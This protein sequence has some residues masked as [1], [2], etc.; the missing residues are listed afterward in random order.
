MERR[1]RARV[2]QLPEKLVENEGR[3]VV[4]ALFPEGLQAFPVVDE[5]GKKRLHIKRRAVFGPAAFDEAGV[6]E[7]A[8]PEGFEPSL[9]P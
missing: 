3:A 1:L 6:T 8:S 9:P 2:D 7:S 4:E 5:A